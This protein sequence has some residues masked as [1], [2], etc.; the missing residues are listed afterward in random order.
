MNSKNSN[1][2]EAIAFDMDG[3]L[4]PFAKFEVPNSLKTALI[5]LPI[6]LP[7][8]MCTGRPIDYIRTKME[9]ILEKAP[10]LEAQMKRWSFLANNGVTGFLPNE[11][12]PFFKVRWPSEMSKIELRGI[13]KADYADYLRVEVR[14]HSLVVLYPEHFYEST[15]LVK[16]LSKRMTRDLNQYFEDAGISHVFSAQNSG[17]G[18]LVIPQTAGKGKALKAWSE[19]MNISLENIVCIG[20]SPGHQENDEEF[21]SGDYG[22]SYT[23]GKSTENPLPLA[24]LNEAGQALYGPEGTEYLLAKLK[25]SC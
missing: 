17:L 21:L 18:T 4:T 11:T 7:L 14:D 1:T 10:N 5:N 22:R 23:V 6:E 20:D 12:E 19:N 2:T 15:A 25:F 8:I 24:V 13:I 16:W 9:H 3:T